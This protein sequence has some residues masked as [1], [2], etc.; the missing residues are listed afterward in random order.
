VFGTTGPEQNIWIYELAGSNA[1]RRLTFGGNNRF[2]IWS[3]DG[4]RVV[5]QSDRDGASAVYWQAADGSGAPERLTM[6]EPA[7]AH[8]PETWLPGQDRF[9]FTVV[10]GSKRTLWTFSVGNRT[11]G[12]LDEVETADAVPRAAAVSPDG[13]WMVYVASDIEAAATRGIF[14][15]PLPPSGATYQVSERSA[16]QQPVWSSDGR[17]I[18]FIPGGGQLAA[19]RIGA[20]PG[21]TFSKPI[22][23]RRAFT[24]NL[25]PAYERNYDVTRDGRFIG[26]VAAEQGDEAVPSGQIKVVLN[27]FEELKARVPTP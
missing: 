12:R 2:P 25:A 14:V 17:D 4:R 26:F 21:F 27:W 20:G 19:V 11:S 5:F 23:L 10:A 13:K 16:G 3:A 8:I 7:T 15:Q 18:F 24:E 22:D 6:P 1:A 9:L